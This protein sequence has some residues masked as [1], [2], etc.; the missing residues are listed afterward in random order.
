MKNQ[1]AIKGKTGIQKV[2]IHG[3]HVYC[4]VE[5]RI[6][7][8][9]D[10]AEQVVTKIHTRLANPGET[11]LF[12]TINKYLNIKNIRKVI[13][14]SVEKCIKCSKCKASISKYGKLSGGLVS[15]N[16]FEYIAVDIL[17]PLKTK[18]F[19][20]ENDKEYFYIVV[21]IDIASR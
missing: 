15:K 12:E 2:N 21:I 18:H 14:K 7:I 6:I 17:G 20:R 13:K 11:K 19:M 1:N 5:Y 16:N 3:K 8:P 4:D 10:I 9:T